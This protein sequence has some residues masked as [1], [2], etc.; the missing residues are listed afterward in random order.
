MIPFTF[1]PK[2][3][4]ETLSLTENKLYCHACD[5]VLYL[6][7]AAAVAV[8]IRHED[9]ILL[10]LRNQNPGRGKLDL[11]GGFC[12]PKESAEETCSREL[13]EELGLPIH[14]DQL[15][16][17]KSLPNVYAYKGIDYNTMDL[18]FEYRVDQ[19]DIVEKLEFQEISKVL[20]VKLSALH[21]EDIAFESQKNFLQ[22]YT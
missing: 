12:D 11:P 3:S 20:W 15:V 13:L 19:K 4:K 16:F 5:F 9:E 2:C 17:I 8:I 14:E 1:C 7:C 18:F 21:L 22:H 10:T 6:N